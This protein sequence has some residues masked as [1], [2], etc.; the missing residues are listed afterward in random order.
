M[1]SR[2]LRKLRRKIAGISAKKTLIL[3]AC[4]T[5]TLLGYALGLLSGNVKEKPPHVLISSQELFSPVT[6]EEISALQR[7]Q[8]ER[9]EVLK[10]AREQMKEQLEASEDKTSAKRPATEV[11]VDDYLSWTRENINDFFTDNEIDELT[12]VITHE[13]LICDSETEWAAHAWVM[14]TRLDD[15]RFDG[16]TIHE[17]ITAENQ[18]Q[19]YE[20]ALALEVN[21]EIREVVVDVMARYI[22]EKNSIYDAETIGRVIPAKYTYWRC[23]S[24]NT[25]NVFWTS[26]SG[27]DSYEP[28][29]DSADF[30]PY[31]T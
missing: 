24:D 18:I 10:K 29:K 17:L 15:P 2:R 28:I 3:L 16:D 6:A 11:V 12:K 23:N 4:L 30:T 14:L 31:D 21:E 1:Y 9:A 25:H 8:R 7:E 19:N 20:E 26:W 5:S 27:G 13:D 22:L